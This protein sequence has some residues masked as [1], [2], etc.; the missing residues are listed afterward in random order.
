MKFKRYFIL[1][2]AFVLLFILFEIFLQIVNYPSNPITPNPYFG[3]DGKLQLFHETKNQ[4]GEK[5]Y[6]TKPEQL[7]Y[8][9]PQEFK[10]TKSENVFRIFCFGGSAVSGFPYGVEVSFPALLQ[11]NL[12][13]LESYQKF[14]VIN[15]GG[16]SLGS[17]R[18]LNLQKEILHYQP[19]MFVF[20]LGHNEF[21]EKNLFEEF[22]K[23]Q[24]GEKL[25]NFTDNIK[26]L[27]L[28]NREDKNSTDRYFKVTEFP[29]SFIIGSSSNLK[30][31]TCSNEKKQN[32]LDQFRNNVTKM[33]ELAHQN[34]VNILLAK[35]PDNI[36]EFSPF[37]SKHKEGL[38][39]EH[40]ENWQKAYLRG[41]IFQKQEKYKEA[42][43]EYQK[44]FNFDDQY[45]ELTFRIAQCLWK[46]KE[47]E[48]AKEYFVQAKNLDAIPLRTL[49]EMNEALQNMGKTYNV[50]V[51]D[52][53]ADISKNSLNGLSD[54]SQ[55]IDHIHPTIQGNQ[56]I[57]ESIAN[58]LVEKEI[59]FSNKKI[60]RQLL[61]RAYGN[62]IKSIPRE[63]FV[64]SVLKVIKNLEL[65]NKKEEKKTILLRNLAKASGNA[66]YNYYIG[67]S[68]LEDSK[69]LESLPYFQNA[70]SLDPNYS[71]AY[72]LLGNALE[73][74]GQ[75][76]EA[77]KKYQKAVLINSQDYEA[78]TNVGR[79]YYLKQN[80]EASIIAYEAALR[81]NPDYPKVHSELGVVYYHYQNDPRHAVKELQQAVALDSNFAEAFFNL[82]VIYMESKELSEAMKNFKQ[83]I[84]SDPFY[85]DA[86]S[87][88][89]VCYYRQKKFAEAQENLELAILI[90][91]KSGQA[92]NNLAV[93]FYGTSNFEK[94]LYHANLA[95]RHHFV[96]HPE[97]IKEIQIGLE[98][99]K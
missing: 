85:S 82:G 50:P 29:I 48:I 52:I 6:R 28:F 79:I 35:I 20:Y 53:Q 71:E 23:N 2:S 89:G 55:F 87:S 92:H 1:L 33:I 65:L 78:R 41:L 93:V 38:T 44:C 22:Q 68:F 56:T 8:F 34:R 13:L 43:T 12:D 86:Y 36:R 10:K 4:D 25:F 84:K 59:I 88:L 76:D 81:I 74:S 95:Q 26:T 15:V 5:I 7:F 45:A 96:I 42:L 16:I 40:L 31:Y 57:A 63:Q 58:F 46:L 70:V 72:N 98:Q 77:L 94:A 73:K 51:V 17:K 67:C 75:P 60:N 97:L 27:N 83:A 3:F 61:A 9:N 90:N 66:E 32:V 62:I 18:I 37:K 19:D 11:T 30:N 47:F 64:K 24:K 49:E 14:E 91:P 39:S 69:F 21:L 80:Y 54:G 99:K